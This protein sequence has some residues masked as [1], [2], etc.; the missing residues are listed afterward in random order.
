MKHSLLQLFIPIALASGIALGNSCNSSYDDFLSEANKAMK[1]FQ[2]SDTGSSCRATSPGEEP[3]PSCSSDET[4]ESAVGAALRKLPSGYFADGR[5][6]FS[7]A[8]YFIYFYAGSKCGACNKLMP[9]IVKEYENIL[10]SKRVELILIGYEE[11]ICGVAGYT[12]QYNACFPGL[13][14][15]CKEVADLPGNVP[16]KSIPGAVFVDKDGNII[17]SGKGSLILEW[18]K[19][20]INQNRK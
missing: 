17:K 9:K 15:N 5:K 16:T 8:D 12:A 7:D 3:D 13:W 4:Q 6:A 10:K 18:K 1:S 11:K 14:I 20:T 19:Y 2:G